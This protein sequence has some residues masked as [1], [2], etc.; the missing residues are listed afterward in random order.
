ML[1]HCMNKYIIRPL[2]DESQKYASAA[3]WLYQ[4]QS[5]H[6]KYEVNYNLPLSGFE[7]SLT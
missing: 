2:I 5:T 7:V 4:M 1:T 3:E 6:T